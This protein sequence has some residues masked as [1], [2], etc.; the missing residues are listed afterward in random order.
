M[1]VSTEQADVK[2]LE[3][4]RRPEKKPRRVAVGVLRPTRAACAAAARR[5]EVL[6][7]DL[8]GVNV[9]QY[10]RPE[11]LAWVFHRVRDVTIQ[12]CVSLILF[13]EF[14]T[15]P[16]GKASGWLR[17][18]LV[19]M[20]DGTFGKGLGLIEFRHGIFVFVG[21]LNHSLQMF[22]GRGRDREF[23]AAKGPNFVSRMARHPDILSVEEE[24]AADYTYMPDPPS[25]HP[26]RHPDQ[27]SARHLPGRRGA[28]AR[29]RRP[30]RPAPSPGAPP[31]HPV[32]RGDRPDQP[33]V[34]RPI[35]VPPRQRAA[36]RPARHARR[37]GEVP[38]RGRRRRVSRP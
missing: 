23:I 9:S 20:H 37:P 8:I 19:P 18:F 33:A 16:D 2:R 26:A 6:D 5:G 24:T 21:G 11:E 17:A 31:R 29:R 28:L 27:V 35:P 22:D 34:R 25:R 38:R 15:V 36:G 32:P 12:Q 7:G 30:E 13:D 1:K 4:A 10:A 14:E 3:I